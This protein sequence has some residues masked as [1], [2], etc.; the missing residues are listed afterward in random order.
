MREASAAMKIQQEREAADRVRHLARV[1]WLTA[2][3]RPVWADGTPL[4]PYDRV[5]MLRQSKAFIAGLI[6]TETRRN[7]REY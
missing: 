6:S 5:D 2:T 4:S 7:A 1:G 3:E